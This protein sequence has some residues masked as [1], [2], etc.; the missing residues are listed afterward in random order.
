MSFPGGAVESACQCR[1]LRFYP[2]VK[3]N[4]WRRKRQPTPVFLPRES[5]GQSSLVGY[6]PGGGEESD[7]TEANER[8]Q[9]EIHSERKNE[10]PQTAALCMT[11][12]TLHFLQF[13]KKSKSQTPACCC[14]IINI[15]VP[16][17]SKTMLPH[18]TAAPLGLTREPPGSDPPVQTFPGSAPLRAQGVGSVCG[19]ELGALR[20]ACCG[21]WEGMSCLW[22]QQDREE[23]L[24]HS[25][26][27]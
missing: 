7:V 24:S 4:P 9:K 17:N 2:W 15:Q 20:W 25:Q 1:K 13:Y 18:Q 11:L 8:A 6:S 3:K 19:G 23:R 27:P 16:P 22:P 12:F 14:S 26:D 5:L 10:P 21:P